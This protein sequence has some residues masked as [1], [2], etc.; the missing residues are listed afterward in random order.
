M[1]CENTEE[2]YNEL[3][4]GVLSEDCGLSMHAQADIQTDF[5]LI[6]DFNKWP[7][8]IGIIF[9][10]SFLPYI[11]SGR[12]ENLKMDEYELSQIRIRNC[13]E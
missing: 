5:E 8:K 10:G 9:T 4:I 12:S 1:R 2:F 7:V 6:S 3:V 11:E 13:D